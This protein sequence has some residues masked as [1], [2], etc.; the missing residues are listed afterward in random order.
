M[1][2]AVDDER[3]PRAAVMAL[4]ERAGEPRELIWLPGIHVQSNRKDV[5]RSLVNTV[6]ERAAR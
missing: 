6:L 3:M 1:I 4:Y 2:N 5:L